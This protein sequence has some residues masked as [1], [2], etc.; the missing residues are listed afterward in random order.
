MDEQLPISLVFV[1]GTW[2]LTLESGETLELRA[3]GFS[4]TEDFYVF[5]S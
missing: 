1:P 3:D 2:R 4:T 5:W